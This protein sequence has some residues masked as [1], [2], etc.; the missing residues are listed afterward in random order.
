MN[1]KPYLPRTSSSKKIATKNH[2]KGLPERGIYKYIDLYMFNEI[3][4]YIWNEK[5]KEK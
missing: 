3:Y 1:G 4:I 5:E 2:I